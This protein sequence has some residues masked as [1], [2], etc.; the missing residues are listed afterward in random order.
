MNKT[1]TLTPPTHVDQSIALQRFLLH[2]IPA[3]GREPAQPPLHSRSSHTSKGKETYNQ[4]DLTGLSSFDGQPGNAGAFPN[5]AKSAGANKLTWD[6]RSF[7]LIALHSADDLIQIG[8]GNGFNADVH[9]LSLRRHFQQAR[10]RRERHPLDEKPHP[11]VA[12]PDR[13][14]QRDQE[15]HAV[16][17]VHHAAQHAIAKS[18][19]QTPDQIPGT[20]LPGQQMSN[21]PD[22][23]RA[24][25]K[26]PDIIDIDHFENLLLWWL[27]TEPASKNELRLLLG[28]ASQSCSLI[29]C[30][31][32][33]DGVR[34]KPDRAL[35][36]TL[37]HSW[38]TRESAA[39]RSSM[40]VRQPFGRQKSRSCNPG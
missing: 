38:R 34:F 20:V 17:A 12:H 14:G 2:E 25:S 15:A 19:A 24:Q 37:A 32:K 40:S 28:E 31:K 11:A 4:G 9:L 16:E 36:L 33:P 5:S 29:A 6:I 27:Q 10:H 22:S 26:T 35:R 7:C 3:P 23:K 30:R 13:R 21:P 8:C 1:A 39:P 18:G